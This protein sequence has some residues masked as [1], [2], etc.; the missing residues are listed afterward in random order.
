MKVTDQTKCLLTRSCIEWQDLSLQLTIASI[1]NLQITQLKMVNKIS[2][3]GT[4]RSIGV[5]DV[6]D[7]ITRL[8]WNWTLHSERQQTEGSLPTY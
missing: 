5:K 1:R 4:L 8:K 6:I 2:N 3:E 7:C